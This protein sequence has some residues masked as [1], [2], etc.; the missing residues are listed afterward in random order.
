MIYGNIALRAPEP[1]D[2]ELL[3][4]WENNSE[5]WRVSNTLAPFS[6]HAIRKHIEESTANIYESGQ[7]RFIICRSDDMDPVGAIDLFEFDSF[8]LRAG[9]G[10]LIARESDRR[11][12]YALNALTALTEYC[13]NHLM[14][15]QLW[16]NILPGN[17]G[18]TALF[19]KAGFLLSGVKKE[20]IKEK[21][22]FSDEL[23]YQ[24]INPSI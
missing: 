3:Y 19:E 14:M 10:I 21:D 23:F 8:H 6:R 9:V 2:T 17:S 11:R 12:G 22:G 18:S 4:Q 20:W 13:F 5:I 1:D 24:L 15:H 7:A 16:C